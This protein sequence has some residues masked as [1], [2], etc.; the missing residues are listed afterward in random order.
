MR[1]DRYYI[2][3]DTPDFDR[4]KCLIFFNDQ[5]RSVRINF[6]FPGDRLIILK[7]A[8]FGLFDDDEFIAITDGRGRN[9]T[10]PGSRSPIGR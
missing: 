5:P 10:F 6:G 7:R 8:H 3:P 2:H 1:T 4:S 9:D